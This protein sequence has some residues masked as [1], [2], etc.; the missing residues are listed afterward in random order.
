MAEHTMENNK[1]VSPLIVLTALTAVGMCYWQMQRRVGVKRERDAAEWATTEGMAHWRD[2]ERRH[3]A[4]KVEGPERIEGSTSPVAT[5]GEDAKAEADAKAAL[6]LKRKAAI[7]EALR[8]Q[9]VRRLMSLEAKIRPKF[10]ALGLSDGQWERYETLS[11]EKIYREDDMRRMGRGGRTQEEFEAALR[12]AGAETID[13]IKALIG[14]TAY[15]ELQRFQTGRSD[16]I[17]LVVNSLSDRLLF[18][19]AP[20]E[21]WQAEKL[22]QALRFQASTMASNDEAKPPPDDKTLEVQRVLKPAQWWAW[23]QLQVENQLLT[24]AGAI[25]QRFDAAKN[26]PTR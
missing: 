23:R 1:W 16:P 10:H 18:S 13:E 24:D 4:P 15:E 26:A 25:A 11:L 7:A 2:L 20:L 17:R 3:S 12:A 9:R 5:I 14:V 21:T 6:Q 19:N 8:T 22:T